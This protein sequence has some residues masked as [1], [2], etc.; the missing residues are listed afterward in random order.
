MNCRQG[1]RPEPAPFPD[2]PD[3]VFLLN[4]KFM[5]KDAIGPAAETIDGVFIVCDVVKL[6][7]TFGIKSQR[8]AVFIFT[9][10][11]P[12]AALQAR[13]DSVVALQRTYRARE[14]KFA[15]R[16]ADLGWS[17]PSGVITI[18]LKVAENGA[19]WT[20]TGTLRYLLFFEGPSSAITVSGS[21]P[22]R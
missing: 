16:L 7:N 4:G 18:D 15:T 13:L 9:K 11:G 3:V 14:G 19:S 1:D 2:A 8:G 12:K 21:R 17:D 6:Y 5:D 22:E 20:A 10:P